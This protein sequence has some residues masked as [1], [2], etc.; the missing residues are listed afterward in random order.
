MAW[1]RRDHKDHLI[2]SLLPWALCTR[3]R[4]SGLHPAWPWT[5]LGMRHPPLLWF[6][7]LTT[8]TGKYFFLVSNLNLHSFSLKPCILVLSLHALV[9][10][11]SSALLLTPFR[12][13]KVLWSLSEAFPSSDWTASSLSA[14]LH[15]SPPAFCSFS[16]S[17]SGLAPTVSHP[18]AGDSRSEHSNAGRVP[19]EQNQLLDLLAMLLV[20]QPRV[21]LAF[22]AEHVHCQLKL[23]LSS[24]NTWV[25]LKAT[26]DPLSTQPLLAWDCP[27][28]GAGHCICPCWTSWGLHRLTSQACPG[29]SGW[30]LFPAVL[31]VTPQFAF[32]ASL[33]MASLSP[34]ALVPAQTSEGHQPSWVSTRTLSH[35]P[36]FFNPINTKIETWSLGNLQMS[37]GIV[38]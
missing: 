16:Q 32:S 18:Y 38:L 25:L 6:R 24:H 34:L 37:S 3:S 29:P 4:C 17:S 13:W 35:W 28:P 22:W 11:A 9:N 15:R 8:L 33:P 12:Y 26:L 14:C 23:S 31:L 7:D 10:S 21:Q 20:M 30:H 2:P 5:F 36:Q 27:D 19:K 1:I